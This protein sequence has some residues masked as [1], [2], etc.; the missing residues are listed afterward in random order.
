M[1]RPK[2]WSV[3]WLNSWSFGTHSMMRRSTSR[4]AVCWIAG[5]KPDVSGS[6]TDQEAERGT[7]FSMGDTPASPNIYETVFRLLVCRYGT[8]DPVG[9]RLLGAHPVEIRAAEEV[10]KW[11]FANQKIELGPAGQT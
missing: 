2:S 8:A 3:S 7:S 5:G 9:L 1:N 10:A 6:D 4:P 11:V